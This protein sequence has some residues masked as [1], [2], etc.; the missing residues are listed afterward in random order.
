MRGLAAA[1]LLGSPAAAAGWSNT[2]L[3]PAEPLVQCIARAELTLAG[4]APAKLETGAWQAAAA[5]ISGGLSARIICLPERVV[6]V[7]EGDPAAKRAGLCR[8][9]VTRW[10]RTG[11]GPQAEC[12]Q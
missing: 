1:L 4:L 6:L 9:I 12:R 10:K 3:G 7:I 5:G 2:D 8:R 11:P